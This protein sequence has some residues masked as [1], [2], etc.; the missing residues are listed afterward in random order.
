MQVADP[1]AGIDA[2]LNI[3]L[4]DGNS[5]FRLPTQGWCMSLSCLAALVRAS[6][7]SSLEPQFACLGE[8]AVKVCLFLSYPSDITDSISPLRMKILKFDVRV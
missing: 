7:P 8:L 1:K 2:I 3:T 6:R 4:Q 5:S